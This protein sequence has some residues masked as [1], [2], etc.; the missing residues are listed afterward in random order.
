MYTE[1]LAG[2]GLASIPSTTGLS[3]KQHSSDT[4]LSNGDSSRAYGSTA[5]AALAMALDHGQPGAHEGWTRVSGASTFAD[6][7]RSF[8][9]NDAPNL[10]V[11]PRTQ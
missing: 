6:S 9:T 4:D 11:L 10:G 3:L 1:L 5:V 2:Y 7:F 8:V